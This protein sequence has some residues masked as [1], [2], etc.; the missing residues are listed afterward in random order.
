MVLVLLMVCVSFV[1]GRCAG[2]LRCGYVSV[3]EWFGDS[4]WV[5]LVVD[6][7]YMTVTMAALQEIGECQFFV[8]LFA[9]VD[10]CTD[11]P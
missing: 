3:R 7:V 11:P 4:G 2:C 1:V 9:I 10:D 6:G 5:C 8:R